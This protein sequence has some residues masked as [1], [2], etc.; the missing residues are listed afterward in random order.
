MALP[1]S[2]LANVQ[3]P[4]LRAYVAG[5]V[6][7]ALTIFG[8]DEVIVFAEDGERQHG[9]TGNSAALLGRILQYLECP[10]YLRKMLFPRSPDLQHAGLLNPL[11]APHHPRRHEWLRYREGVIVPERDGDGQS[12]ASSLAAVGLDQP[13]RLT[14]TPPL[15]VG[16]R[17]TVQLRRRSDA[18]A[19]HAP[20]HRKRA[21][22][23]SSCDMITEATPVS[24]EAPRH[25]HGLYWGYRVRLADS[26]QHAVELSECDV[27]IGTSDKGH[28]LFATAHPGLPD[29]RLCRVPVGGFRHLLL[30][31][32]GVHG[33][34]HCRPSDDPVRHLFD[35]Y[36]NVCPQQGSR[37]IRTEEA[38]FIALSA[39]Q[40]WIHHNG[41]QGG[42]GE[43]R[44]ET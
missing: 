12:T 41:Y 31:F 34:E 17:V 26:L 15:A 37:T 8:V 9:W 16:T 13:V 35:A 36:I 38:L 1:G 2:F 29:A 33:L 14:R 11:D 23:P 44:E 5:Q 4:E 40:P 7:R 42:S 3:T 10:Q 25:A 43:V 22:R 27:K 39:M 30:A 24:P 21:R 6:A 18:S 19:D 32:G 28:N 20:P